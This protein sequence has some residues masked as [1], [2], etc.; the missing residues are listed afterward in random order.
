MNIWMQI[1]ILRSVSETD[2]DLSDPSFLTETQILVLLRKNLKEA[3][4]S[5]QFLSKPISLTK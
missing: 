5:N 4:T 1:H 3:C 2:F